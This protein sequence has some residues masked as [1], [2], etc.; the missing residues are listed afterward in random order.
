MITARRIGWLCAAAASA[1]L[2]L[3]AAGAAA[4]IV[5]QH[6]IAGAKIGQTE[7]RVRDVLG[8]PVRTVH[9]TTIFGP[10]TRLL[11]R[12]LT[13]TLQGARRVTSVST[14]SP[15]HRTRGGVGVGSTEARA[16]STIRGLTCRSL[17]G[18]RSCVLGA[19]EPGRRVTLLRVRDGVVRQVVIGIVID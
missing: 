14:R 8:A 6:G 16:R 7:E 5:P 9:D 2:A 15:A 1:G 10:R 4:L 19:E 13:V 3:P 12:G 18:V 17:G 11:Y